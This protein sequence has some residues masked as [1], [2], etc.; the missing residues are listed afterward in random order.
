MDILA[1]TIDNQS[2]DVVVGEV[3]TIQEVPDSPKTGI[4]GLDSGQSATL[5]ISV[6]VVP[7]ALILLF[8]VKRARHQ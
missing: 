6:I 2:H 8:L 1:T 5:M 3:E 4:F 7:V